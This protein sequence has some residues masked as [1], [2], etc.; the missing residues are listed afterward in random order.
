MDH[1]HTSGPTH[2]PRKSD[3]AHT[4]AL[5]GHTPRDVAALVRCR[6]GVG[7]VSP[8]PTAE[9][10]RELLAAQP[11]CVPARSLILHINGQEFDLT[12]VPGAFEDF[13]SLFP[14]ASNKAGTG[15]E[16]G[17]PQGGPPSLRP[18]TERMVNP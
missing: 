4:G 9:Q 10:P 5:V 7:V 1:T 12:D 3:N 6:G 8:S 11:R 14:A 17:L 2:L 13:R 18:D 16:G 15:G